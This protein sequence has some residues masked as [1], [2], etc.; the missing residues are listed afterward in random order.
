[1]QTEWFLS[2]YSITEDHMIRI[3]LGVGGWAGGVG[4][5]DTGPPGSLL[6]TLLIASIIALY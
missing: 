4:G 6:D 3:I 5:G 1:M 2:C